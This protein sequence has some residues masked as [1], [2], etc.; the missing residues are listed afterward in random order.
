VFST[1]YLLGISGRDLWEVNN[2]SM[3]R[4]FKLSFSFQFGVQI[5]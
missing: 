4:H 1:I 3:Q 2:R 5:K